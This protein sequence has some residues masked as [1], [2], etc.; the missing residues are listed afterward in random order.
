MGIIETVFMK[1]NKLFLTMNQTKIHLLIRAE[2]IALQ[3]ED[4]VVKEEMF[5]L[6]F[7]L[8]IEK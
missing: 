3:H 6:F 5:I 1:L 2:Y 7:I 8:F 4:I